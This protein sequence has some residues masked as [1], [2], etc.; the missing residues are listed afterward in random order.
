MGKLT[1]KTVKSGA[2]EVEVETT[3]TVLGV[4]ELLHSVHNQDPPA[5]QRA[6]AGACARAVTRTRLSC[7]VDSDLARGDR[8][9]PSQRLHAYGEPTCAK[10]T[11]GGK[12]PAAEDC[13][14]G[15]RS[16]R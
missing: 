1:V 14:L 11:V 7:C 8:S 10:C 9:V 2:F 13:I 12:P 16:T 5:S 6:G 4:K 15:L 3:T